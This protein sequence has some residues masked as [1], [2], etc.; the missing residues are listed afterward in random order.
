MLL[1]PFPPRSRGQEACRCCG[2]EEWRA[3]AGQE[4]T[5]S[6]AAT[7]LDR[8]D[9][10][11]HRDLKVGPGGYDVFSAFKGA[12]EGA[13]DSP[14]P[15]EVEGLTDESATIDHEFAFRRR[16]SV[17]DANAKPQVSG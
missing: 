13:R 5:K 10:M 8:I 3:E 16:A 2:V 15:K 17:D 12:F 6:G 7:I 14:C 1:F 11:S 4:I 9:R